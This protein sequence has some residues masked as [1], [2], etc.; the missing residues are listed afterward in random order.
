MAEIGA[1][2]G[3][4]DPKS[5]PSLVSGSCSHR[6]HAMDT[7]DIPRREFL[8]QGGTAVAGLTLANVPFLARAFPTRPGE[9]VIPW[10][11]EMPPNPRQAWS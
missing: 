3:M 7:G 6:R 2:S 1:R 10:L 4:A 5:L 11:E 8:V 9:E